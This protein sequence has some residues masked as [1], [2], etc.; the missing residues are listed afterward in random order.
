MH[1]VKEVKVNESEIEE[2][3]PAVY[4]DLKELTKQDLIK[5]FASIEFNRFL[6]YYRNAPD[7]NAD[8]KRTEFGVVRNTGGT[9][10]FINLGKMDGLDKPQMLELIDEYTGLEKKDIGTIDLKGAYSFFEVEKH[11]ADRVVN[12]FKNVELQGRQ[13]RVEITDVNA[14]ASL[15]GGRRD[16]NSRPRKRVYP[17]KKF[18]GNKRGGFNKKWKKDR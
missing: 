6:D 14:G 1:K 3:L 8:Q 7:L 2:F 11:Q 18:S 16:E 4:E 15:S 5:R 10:F 12:G 9:R 13:V 17:D